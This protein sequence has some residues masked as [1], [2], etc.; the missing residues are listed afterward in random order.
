M[1]YS[2]NQ[3][4]KLTSKTIQQK[5]LEPSSGKIQYT[6]AS[7]NKLFMV[8]EAGEFDSV[9]VSMNDFQLTDEK[10][11]TE[12][13]LQLNYLWVSFSVIVVSLLAWLIYRES[14]FKSLL[15]TVQNNG[16]VLHASSDE[17]QF[18]ALEKL[19]LEEFIKAR[20]EGAT[21]TVATMNA[22]LGLNKKSL[23]VQKKTRNEMV[24]GINNKHKKNNA[25]EEDLIIRVRSSVDKRYF[26]YV[27]ND[28]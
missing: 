11:Y 8:N 27:L 16:S 2:K 26:E 20:K 15:K 25:T 21:I 3:V 14:K 7:K 10:I 4:Y 19:L 17:L 13:P 22:L 5:I 18:T 24:N 9:I 6:F 28:G 1:K 23:E 12:P